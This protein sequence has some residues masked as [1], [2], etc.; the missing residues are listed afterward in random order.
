[1]GLRVYGR[2]IE[3][4]IFDVDGVILDLM[5]YFPTNLILAARDSGLPDYTI[6]KYFFDVWSGNR[7]PKNGLRENID[8][9]FKELDI[10]ITDKLINKFLKNL[11]NRE[12]KHP[13]KLIEKS[14]D[15]ILLFKKYGKVSLCTSNSRKMLEEKFTAL[16]VRIPLDIFSCIST[17]DEDSANAAKPDP[18]A[19][20]YIFEETGVTARESMFFGDWHP[21]V[22]AANCFPK[23]TFIGVTSGGVTKDTFIKGLGVKEDRIFPSIFEAYKNF[24]KDV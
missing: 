11:N 18:R 13:Y 19:L 3:S 16:D 2:N 12:K 4:F 5:A 8:D 1:M 17:P 22:W 9:I 23:M 14:L 7:I 6:Q 24:K 10:K 15:A 20:Q 21:D